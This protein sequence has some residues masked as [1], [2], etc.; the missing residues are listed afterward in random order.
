MDGVFVPLPDGLDEMP[1][2]PALGE[3]LSRLDRTRFNG[4]QLVRLMQARY[5][6]MCWQQ[7]ELWAD[8]YAMAYTYG[9]HPY[10]PPVWKRQRDEHLEEEV[11]FA[12]SFTA[13]TAEE[14]T[15][16]A[17][18]TT[19]L[20]PNLGAAAAAGR[21]DLAKVQAILREVEG[22]GPE[23]AAPLI[24]RILVD[25]DLHTTG[26]IRSDL[27]RLVF[28]VAPEAARKRHKKAVSDR[29]VTCTQHNDGTATITARNLPPDRAV[30]TMDY[31][32]RTATA[33]HQAGD[34][35][36]TRFDDLDRRTTAQIRADVFLDL[37]AGG[38][39]HHLC[40]R[41]WCRSSQPSTRQRLPQPHRR[42]LNAH[43]FE[44]P[45]G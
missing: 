15:G 32:N 43:V 21:I 8:M 14:H 38:S 26:R 31:L 40:R 13:H 30:K 41:G 23:Q 10:A 12:L 18:A 5:R 36:G 22:L 45:P 7:T 25:A 20:Y 44:R 42:T 11:A 24:D 28:S 19:E 37:T 6:Q 17:Y 16:L 35:L 33:T 2:G 1:P 34:P 4:Y 39:S 29:N 27:R 9:G 3:L